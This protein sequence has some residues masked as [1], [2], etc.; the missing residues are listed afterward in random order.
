MGA[1]DVLERLD[2]VYHP[3]CQVVGVLGQCRNAASAT[4]II[5]AN[6]SGTACSDNFVYVCAACLRRLMVQVQSA[7]CVVPGCDRVGVAGFIQRVRPLPVV[8]P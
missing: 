2:W 4:A 7:P 3:S 6:N 1:E 8:T 5:H